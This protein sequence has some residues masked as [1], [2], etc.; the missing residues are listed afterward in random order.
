MV[1]YLIISKI[2]AHLPF[3]L[4]IP[5]LDERSFKSRIWSI[6]EENMQVIFMVGYE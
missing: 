4:R 6:K 3:E 2:V 1:S 5:V